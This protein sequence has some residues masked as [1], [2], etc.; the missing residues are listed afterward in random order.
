[1]AK[2]KPAAKKSSKKSKGGKSKK[3]KSDESL[4][5]RPIIVKGGALPGDDQATTNGYTVLVEAEFPANTSYHPG[6]DYEYWSTFPG[7]LVPPVVTLLVKVDGEEI[8]I[9]VED[10]V[11]SITLE[12]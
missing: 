8:E 9:K 6:S 10:T 7:N 11:W 2:A 1:M 3:R 12:T 4:S 5:G